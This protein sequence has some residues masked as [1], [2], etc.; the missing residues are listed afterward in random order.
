MEKRIRTRKSV[1]IKSKN[2]VFTRRDPGMGSTCSL[3]EEQTGKSREE[4][5]W[6]NDEGR[7]ETRKGQRRKEKEQWK[8]KEGMRNKEAEEERESRRSMRR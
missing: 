8:K 6:K 7:G 1:C 3:Q 4:R 2:L 5:R